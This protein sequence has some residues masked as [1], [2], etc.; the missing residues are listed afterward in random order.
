MTRT[1]P[2]LAELAERIADEVG[3]TARMLMGGE[4]PSF[5]IL[6]GDRHPLLIRDHAWTLTLSFPTAHSFRLATPEDWQAIAAE[7]KRLASESYPIA[8]SDAVLAIGPMLGLAHV[9]ARQ[10]ALAS[11]PRGRSPDRAK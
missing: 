7:V 5:A 2:A 4:H 3:G 10:Q 8:M 1:L 9:G 6:L 11:L